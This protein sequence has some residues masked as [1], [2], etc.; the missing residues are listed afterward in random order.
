MNTRRTG[1]I[2][3]LLGAG[4]IA[5]ASAKPVMLNTTSSEPEGLYLV[6]KREPA[7]VAPGRY[8]AACPPMSPIIHLG[9]IRHYLATGTCPD[10]TVPVLKQVEAVAGEAV[11]YSAAGIA[12]DGR[13]L[14]NTAPAARDPRGRPLPHYPFGN[15]VVAPNQVWLL[16]TF[17]PLSFDARYFGPVPVADIKAIVRPV[18][19]QR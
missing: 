9:V 16:S 18:W 8:V 15:Y 4:I 5:V 6:V 17:S 1:I 12:V 11:H 7:Q 19:T 2:T 14:P 3:F 13:L 10:G